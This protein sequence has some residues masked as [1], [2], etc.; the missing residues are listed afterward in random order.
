M[1][2]SDIK[3]ILGEKEIRLKKRWGQ[4]FLYDENIL[5]DIVDIAGISKDDFVIEVGPG[6]GTLTEELLKRGAKVAAIEIDRGMC[7]ILNDRLGC[8]PNL[9]VISKNILDIDLRTF[10]EERGIP[11]DGKIKVVSN[12]PYYITSPVIMFFLESACPIATMVFTMQAEVARRVTASPGTKDYGILTVIVNYFSSPKIT[13]KI[14]RGSFFPAPNV[15]S[16]VVRFDVYD[17]PKVAVK[18]RELFFKI[19]KTSFGQRRKTMRNNIGRLSG[20]KEAEEVLK[21]CGIDPSRRAETLT[22]EEFARLTSV[23][24]ARL[25]VLGFRLFSNLDTRTENQGPRTDL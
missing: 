15:D 13:K 23:L 24:G 20:A 17:K 21:E 14:S 11:R 2:L 25:S 9:E 18:D 3:N 5:R 1:K 12:L 10:I 4:N 8:Y 7:E 19:V 16:A 22:I 6:I